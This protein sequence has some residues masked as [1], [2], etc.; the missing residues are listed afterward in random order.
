MLV[1]CEIVVKEKIFKANYCKI[2]SLLIL[3]FLEM[4]DIQQ[5]AQHKFFKSY[6]WW[7]LLNWSLR[8]LIGLLCPGNNV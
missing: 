6:Y 5:E 7:S 3:D 8:L 2:I 4:T 1:T